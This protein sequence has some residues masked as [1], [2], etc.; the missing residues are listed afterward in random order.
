[1][2]VL[3]FDDFVRDRGPALI[4]LARLLTGDP[5]RAEDLVQDTLAQAYPRW[6]RI[7][8]TER[9]DL[10]V[11]RILVNLN[12]S[13]WRRQTN[14]NF[15]GGGP[16]DRPDPADAIR[17]T[18][19]RLTLWEEVA[20]L[21]PRQ[22]AV[23]ALRYY[24]DLDDN[25]IAE[26]LGCSPVTVRTHA[27]RGLAAIRSRLD[28]GDLPVTTDTG[29]LA[30][31]AARDGRR[32]QRTRRATLAAFVA[33]V[34][35]ATAVVVWGS[36]DV[37]PPVPLQPSPDPALVAFAPPAAGRTAAE[38][39]AVIGSD[40][41]LLHI[42]VGSLPGPQGTLIWTT[43]PGQETVDFLLRPANRDDP[44]MDTARLQVSAATTV[45]QTG[46]RVRLPGGQTGWAV[47]GGDHT[48]LSWA[49]T[50]GTVARL[51]T[52]GPPDPSG[53]PATMSLARL[54][55]VAGTIN[56]DHNHRC[57]APFRLTSPAVRLRSCAFTQRTTAPPI[58]GLPSVRFFTDLTLAAGHHE[59]TMQCSATA[60]T[61]PEPGDVTTDHDVAYAVR[62]D[63]TARQIGLR[64][65]IR[66]P[67]TCDISAP[68]AV[69]TTDL[70]TFVNGVVPVGRADD[71]QTWPVDPSR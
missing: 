71:P 29:R 22:R 54:L 41:T 7:A 56:L 65:Q 32:R 59:L 70:V 34:M 44:G 30:T 36:T 45:S 62:T 67:F 8:R 43:G 21:P 17:H 42:A 15:R 38:D 31:A 28:D 6:K 3:D 1:M 57:S 33:T 24:E 46:Q 16:G 51:T 4:R 39:P 25:Q 19:D 35:A 53:Q 13:W 40:P 48:T 66:R 64:A 49:P 11:R 2:N 63:E 52:P 37:P 69:S 10:Y 20:A 55:T 47:V 12:I 14:W 9:P 23:V 26:I 61:S 27:M 68:A 18:A 50:S 5:H 58:P 60:A